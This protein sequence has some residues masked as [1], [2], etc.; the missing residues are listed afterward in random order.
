MNAICYTR[1][2]WWLTGLGFVAIV[3]GLASRKYPEFSPALL[4]NYTGDA[5]WAST[6]YLAIAFV[7]PRIPVWKLA[8]ITLV[9]SYLVEF[10]Q[11]THAHGIDAIR[12]THVGHL[13]LG[14]GF[15]GFDLVAL[16]IGVGLAAGVDA[17]C[18][19]NSRRHAQ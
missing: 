11:L 16:T 15:D 8:G 4:G 17:I 18:E 13:L 3:L 12:D 2:R 10:S 14:Q 6:A 5:L 19:W 9:V 1:N 7:V